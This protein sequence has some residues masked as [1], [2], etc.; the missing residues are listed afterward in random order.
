MDALIQKVREYQRHTAAA[1]RERLVLEILA[2]MCP[3]LDRFVRIHCPV[4]DAADVL[5]ETLNG[6]AL[7]L[8]RFAGE[9]DSQLWALA[10]A[11]ARRK[12]A[13]LFR[14]RKMDHIT[15]VDT[16]LLRES[17]AATDA[18]FGL[19]DSDRADLEEAI[20]LLRTSSPPCLHYLW[21][22]YVAGL[23]FPELGRELG[24]T[25]EAARKR[26]ERCLKLAQEL[27]ER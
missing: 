18:L 9:T 11:I 23:S 6:I 24:I 10:Y 12:R 8:E 15:I 21:D 2:V 4:A 27:M 16:G 19:S 13:D 1:E 14:R 25:E 22:R 17:L 7:W 20:G 3:D 5:Q 26:V